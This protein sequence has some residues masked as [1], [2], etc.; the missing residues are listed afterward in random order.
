VPCAQWI[1]FETTRATAN[2]DCNSLDVEFV[3]MLV[4]DPSR[5]RR[6]MNQFGS[7]HR[8]AKAR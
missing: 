8:R 7:L 4:S 6:M 2:S 1:G 5:L 3:L